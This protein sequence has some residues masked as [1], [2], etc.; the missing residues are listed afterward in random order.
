MHIIAGLFLIYMGCRVAWVGIEEI[1]DVVNG[2]TELY[3]PGILFQTIP[4]VVMIALGLYCIISYARA[5]W[6]RLS[7]INNCTDVH[8]GRIDEWVIE[9]KDIDHGRSRTTS[10]S[11]IV[12]LDAHGKET[13]CKF[14]V[15]IPIESMYP[16]GSKVKVYERDGE[17]AWDRKVLKGC[18]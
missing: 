5:L 13:L 17:F 12:R 6:K 1:M 7:I 10:A 4:G 11:I 2:V 15:P 3:L 18:E 9:S 14:K 16:V 8:E